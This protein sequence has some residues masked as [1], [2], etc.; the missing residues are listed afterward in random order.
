LQLLS[1]PF[2]ATIPTSILAA[3]SGKVNQVFKGGSTFPFW[4]N[5]L[6]KGGS[7]FLRFNF[8]GGY[9][10]VSYNP[11]GS[12]LGLSQ[13][14]KILWPFWGVSPIPVD[15]LFWRFLLKPPK[16]LFLNLGGHT[17]SGG[18]FFPGVFP[19]HLGGKNPLGC[20]SNFGEGVHLCAGTLGPRT[21]LRRRGVLCPSSCTS[22]GLSRGRPQRGVFSSGEHF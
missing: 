20:W 15:P 22:R 12:H 21:L 17:G 19:S 16:P 9:F 5:L 11:L 10:K 3:T 2:I 18:F 7:N 1:W 6:C 8:Q 14:F 13:V 4:D